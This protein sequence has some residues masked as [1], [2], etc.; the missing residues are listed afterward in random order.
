[1]DKKL[2]IS[3][4]YLMP[5]YAYGGSCLPKDLRSLEQLARMANVSVPLISSIR[6][7]NDEH[8]NQSIR[9]IER[10]GKKSLGFHGISF[11]EGTDDLRESPFVRLAEH[12]IGKG[13]RVKIYDEDVVPS[14]LLGANRKF[15]QDTAG[16]ILDLLV[17]DPSELCQCEVIVV[18]KDVPKRIEGLWQGKIVVDLRR[19]PRE[20][21]LQ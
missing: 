16:H 4:K 14:R 20:G 15:I 12:F 3:S 10:Y 7:S 21:I 18:C 5:G 1:M 11:K 17:A 13:Y 19:T 8:I 6:V 9:A 2:N